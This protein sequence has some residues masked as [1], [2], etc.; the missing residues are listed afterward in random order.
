METNNNK[1]TAALIHLSA[2]TQYFIPFGNFIF[3]IILWSAMKDKSIYIDRQGKQIINFQLSLFLYSIVLILIAF[4]I[5]FITV[6]KNIDYKS[7]ANFDHLEIQNFNLEN[8]SGILILA[9]MSVF[10][11]C[12]L[13]IFE[14]FLIIYA[15]AK[16]S[17]GLEFKYPLTI[18]FIK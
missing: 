1:S 13:K 2:L 7:S 9:F 5:F 14:F 6:L 12:A 11:F 10:I 8:I 18:N 17:N 15:S 16:T 4:P 3:P